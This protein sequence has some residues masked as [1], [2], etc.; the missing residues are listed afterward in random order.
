MLNLTNMRRRNA[1]CGAIVSLAVVAVGCQRPSRD[2]PGLPPTTPGGVVAADDPTA[3]LVGAAVLARGGNAVDAAIATALALGVVNPTSSGIGGGGFAIVHVAA[4]GRTYA[5]DFRE[6]APAALDPGDFVVDGVVDPTR[7]VRGGLAVAVP[8]EVAGLELLHRRHG[9]LDWPELVTPAAD[10]AESG[11]DAGFFIAKEAPGVL[12]KLP[13][14]PTFEP[15]RTLIAPRGAAVARGDRIVRA[16]LGETLRAIAAGGADRFY[17]GAIADDLIATV[18][19]AGG[20]ITAADLAGYRVVEREPLRGRWRGLDVATMPLPS[21]GGLVVLEALAILDALAARG[22]D[23]AALDAGSAEALHLA[24]EALKHGFADRARVMGDLD[25]APAIAARLLDPDGL[26]AIARR[27]DPGGIGVHAG[28][29]HPDLGVPPAAPDDGGTSHLC[30]IDADGNAVALTTTVNSF[31]GSKLVTGAG[32]VLNNE[33]DDFALEPGLPNSFGLV[34]GEGNLVAAGKR[35]LSSMTPVLVFDG[36]HVIACTGGSG[37]P[38]IISSVTQV[39][40]GTFVFGLDAAAAVAAPRVHHQWLPDRLEAE[41]GL[42]RE[43]YRALA[44]YGHAVDDAAPDETSAVQLIRR[45]PGGAIEAA[46]DPRK[47]GAPAFP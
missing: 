26:R 31:F 27:I 5:Y 32:I 15:L 42:P 39:L 14:D 30:V 9:A 34:Q 37:G 29:G 23:V 18:A 25:D 33:V 10:L 22:V 43:V 4:E 16:R 13:A 2:R 3:S 41:P 24:V 38:R 6:I 28:Y 7:A 17:R 44:G 46:S 21:S 47:G 40:L 1:T 45:R 11:F 19:A 12:A 8:G 35:P 36:G 20:V